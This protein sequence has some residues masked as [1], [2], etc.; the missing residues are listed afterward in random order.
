MLGLGLAMISLFVCLA[1]V[2][3]YDAATLLQVW[4]VPGLKRI[5]RNDP[6]VNRRE[7]ELS[8]ARGEYEPF[9]IGVRA[10]Q[11][12]TK[13]NVYVS[14]LTGPG[15]AVIAP[16]NVTL[17][18]EHYVNVPTA[19]WTLRNSHNRSRGPGWYADGLIPF[20]DPQ[21][22]QDLVGASLDAAPFA[23]A[24]QDNQAIW[25]DIFVPR[26]TPAGDYTGQFTVTSESVDI[27]GQ[28]R[29]HVWDFEL[30]TQPSLNSSFSFWEPTSQADLAEFTRHKLMPATKL[31]ANDQASLINQWG[32]NS[33]RLPFW[34]G[35]NITT[36]QM[37]APPSIATI[38]N[39]VQQYDDRLLK[40]AYTADEVDR[41]AGLTETIKQWGRNL[42]AAGVKQL[43]V[44]TPT[45]EL[46]D[47][48]SGSGQSA[49]DIWPVL[50][51]QY[52]TATNQIAAAQAKGDEVWSYTALVQDRYSPKWQLDFAPINFRILPGFLNQ[53]LNLTGILYWQVDSWTSNP[54]NQVKIY[55]PQPG[56]TYAGEGMLVYPGATIGTAQISP[57]MRLKW[58]RE[59]VEDYEYVQIL[60]NLGHTSQALNL[61]RRIAAD[62]RNWSDDPQKLATV[63]EQIA[64]A[65]E[66]AS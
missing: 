36:C 64:I 27:T 17:Y 12:L 53:S 34:S 25:V 15:G 18:R 66:Q 52:E 49:V 5:G 1:T 16:D 7:I 57:S 32:L 4:T 23:L 41:C 20:V 37:D 22:Q 28:V 6:P 45:P 8:A 19:S 2:Q 56:Q 26:D 3:T 43:V 9:Q 46:F 54:W 11:P 65:I 47:D 39:S 30:P 50:A 14:D 24:P 35:A 61:S 40:Y 58:L 38:R 63:R 48:D 60:K 13:V 59:G 51:S 31:N 42:H 44:M 10:N 33:V 21:T 62:W 55:A 29:L